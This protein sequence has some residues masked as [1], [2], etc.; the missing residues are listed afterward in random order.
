ML[1]QHTE[2]VQ[3]LMNQSQ[4]TINTCIQ[5][6]KAILRQ[7]YDQV[8]IVAQISKAVQDNTITASLTS[9]YLC[10]QCPI[11]IKE[12]DIAK[13]GQKKSHRF[14]TLTLPP[15]GTRPQADVHLVVDSRSG[16]LFCHMCD[17]FVWDPTLEDLRHRKIGSGT[18]SSMS[19]SLPR[20][21]C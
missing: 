17:D 3:R 10:L 19:H 5:H 8:P 20:L 21:A 12:E 13:H 16:S 6:Y 18:F 15:P 14:C 9:N 7:I 4:E 2:H 11:I 1:T